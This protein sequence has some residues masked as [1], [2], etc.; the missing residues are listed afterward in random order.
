MINEAFFVFWF[1]LPVGLA[2]IAALFAGRI[3]FL[4]KFS[5][6][7][8]FYLKIREKRILGEHK[9]IRGFI[10]GVIIG[11]GTVYLQVFLYKYFGFLSNVIP[12]NYRLVDPVILGSLFWFWSNVWGRRKKFF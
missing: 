9:T 11:I 6:P 7:A 10:V 4:Q 3:R 2:T 1:F 5:Y 12:L 8:D